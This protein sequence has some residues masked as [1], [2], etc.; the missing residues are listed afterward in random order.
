[1]KNKK[2]IL[3]ID[4]S[5]NK[6]TAVGIEI[7]GIKKELINESDN[8]SSQQVLPLIERILKDNRL[9]FTD[10][11]GI[12]IHTGPGSFTG[13]RVGVTVANILSWYYNIP[14]NDSFLPAE[15]VY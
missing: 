13:V 5:N 2:V 3:H 10:L 7:D 8:W 11:T 14:V 6:K 9:K 4:T 15:P 12:R 1:M